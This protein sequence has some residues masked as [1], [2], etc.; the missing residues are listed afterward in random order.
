MS[1]KYCL[2]RHGS[3]S[4]NRHRCRSR[5]AGRS[6]RRATI[7]MVT[8][9]AVIRAALRSRRSNGLCRGRGGFADAGRPCGTA[10]HC[11]PPRA[12]RLAAA[13]PPDYQPSLARRIA[14]QCLPGPPV[15]RRWPAGLPAAAGP[16]DCQAVP[17]AASAGRM[18]LSADAAAA[19][20][21]TIAS[22]CSHAAIAAVD[23][24]R[25]C[26]SR[27]TADT[28]LND[29]GLLW[30]GRP[31]LAWPADPCGQS[32]GH[33][34]SESAWLSFAEDASDPQLERP[35]LILYS[36]FIV[37]PSGWIVH[38]PRGRQ[39]RPDSQSPLPSQIDLVLLS[40]DRCSQGRVHAHSTDRVPL[41]RPPR[42]SASSPASQLLASAWE[43]LPDLYAHMQRPV[44]DRFHWQS[45]WALQVCSSRPFQS[46][47]CIGAG[48]PKLFWS[49]NDGR[50]WT[51]AE[52]QMSKYQQRLS[53]IS[54]AYPHTGLCS[55]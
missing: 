38:G 18:A 24:S 28:W 43:P 48:V 17:P 33:S 37:L 22:Q 31:K 42:P 50:K 32:A 15:G 6:C 29:H 47:P 44:C 11:Q 19:S 4:T 2:I 52:S 1:S 26:L 45:S 30:G 13:G 16:P 40:G 39:W 9:I 34:R 46:R 10:R 54:N 25:R 23:R 3:S 7:S 5:G 35:V 55:S 51:M 27:V 21:Q 53:H 20:R 49:V 12:L 8:A 14:R 41:R 36:P